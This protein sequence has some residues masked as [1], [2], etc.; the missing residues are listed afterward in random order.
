MNSSVELRFVGILIPL[1]RSIAQLEVIVLER[2][3]AEFSDKFPL[4]ATS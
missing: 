1:L 2:L 3:K 4:I